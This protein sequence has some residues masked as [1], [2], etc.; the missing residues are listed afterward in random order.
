MNENLKLSSKL[1]A[2][3]CKYVFYIFRDTLKK[4]SGFFDIDIVFLEKSF[5][6]ILYRVGRVH[7]VLKVEMVWPYLKCSKTNHTQMT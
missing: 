5:F 7:V 2:T 4:L 3:E 6:F 1:F